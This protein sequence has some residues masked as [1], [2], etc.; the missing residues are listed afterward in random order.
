MVDRVRNYIK[1][2]EEHHS[3]QS[4]E[5]EYKEFITKYKFENE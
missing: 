5:E 2:Q 4:Y 1:N 3:K